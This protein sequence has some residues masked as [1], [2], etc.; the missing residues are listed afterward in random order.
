MSG[1]ALQPLYDLG[2]A[3]SAQVLGTPYIWTSASGPNDPASPSR[4]LGTLLAWITTDA[5]L[6]GTAQPQYGKPGWYG[7]FER[8]NTLVGDYLIGQ[9]GTFFIA[10]LDYP[11]PVFL[12]WCNHTISI[13][14]ANDVLAAGSSGTYSGSAVDTALPFMSGWPVYLGQ[15]GTGGKGASSGMA[16]PSDGKLPGTMILMPATCPEVRFNDIVT[17]E[18]G[19]RYT[20]SSVELTPLGYRLTADVWPSA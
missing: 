9:E 18:N 15:L 20:L 13:A 12:T 16:L 5:K 1:A 17:D 4:A 2:Y 6:Q 11:G 3:V 14:R 19:A 7:A 10:S 8:A